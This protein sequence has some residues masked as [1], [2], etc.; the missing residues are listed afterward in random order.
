M[1]GRS[2]VIVWRW[3]PRR[4][5]SAHVTSAGSLDP[6]LFFCTGESDVV[7]G[8]DQRVC[9]PLSLAKQLLQLVIEGNV[10]SVG[11]DV[12]GTDVVELL[13]DV[14][15]VFGWRCGLGVLLR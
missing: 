8:G 13:L 14:E 5:L 15:L 4:M 12:V 3:R 2:A 11:V 1:R 7:A 9:Q 6:K 10:V